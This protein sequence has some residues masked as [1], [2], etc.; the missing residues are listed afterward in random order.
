MEEELNKTLRFIASRMILRPVSHFLASCGLMRTDGVNFAVL[1]DMTRRWFWPCSSFPPPFIPLGGGKA[2]PA[3]F[4]H[5]RGF[6]CSCGL[7]PLL[8]TP[9]LAQLLFVPMRCQYSELFDILGQSVGCNISFGFQLVRPVP[10]IN[11]HYSGTKMNIHHPLH[12]T[13]YITQVSQPRES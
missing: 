2:P 10:T 12:T 13:R 5:K 11:L 4:P 3:L 8:V 1:F 7:C 6:P 9:M